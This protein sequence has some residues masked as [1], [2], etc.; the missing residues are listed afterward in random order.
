M[1]VVGGVWAILEY[2][3]NLAIARVK[4]TLDLHKQYT[5]KK[6]FA[7]KDRLTESV[8]PLILSV[9]CEFI[10]RAVADKKLEM[11]KRPINCNKVDGEVIETLRSYDLKGE[12]RTELRLYVLSKL[13]QTPL[14]RDISEGLAQLSIFFRSII[15][16]VDKNNCDAETSVALFAREM[17][18]FV[19]STCAFDD[20]TSQGG[21]T[22][23]AEIAA[24]LLDMGVHKNIYWS[25][26]PS[27]EKLFLCEALRALE[28]ES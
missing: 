12:L 3:N 2:G 8:G 18:E 26:D 5:D 1:V 25:L 6:M 19:N 23:N 13:G 10:V 21:K 20:Q 11:P 9:R 16:C 4:T 24:F 22:V 27:R 15:V 28:L 7:A 14:S 17:V